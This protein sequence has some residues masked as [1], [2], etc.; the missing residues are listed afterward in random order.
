MNK[1]FDIYSYMYITNFD[2]TVC[3]FCFLGRGGG[4]GGGGALCG[5]GE[6]GVG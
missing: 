5:G 2:I 4:G 1:V 6:G 3:F